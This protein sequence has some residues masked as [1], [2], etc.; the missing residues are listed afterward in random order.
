MGRRGAGA[1]V[2]LLLLGAAVALN[3][4]AAG[5][6]ESP[7]RTFK[8]GESVRGHAIR[9][10]EI[11]YPSAPR[12]ILVVGSLH[13]DERA[14]VG[15]VRELARSAPLEGVDLWL[16]PN[17]NPDGA[18]AHTRQNARGVDLNRNFPHRW[19]RSGN[20]F[21]Q[22]YSGRRP[23][24]EPESRIA[25]DL[26]ERL[27]PRITLWFHQPLGIVDLSGGDGRIERRFAR[28]AGLPVRRLPRYRGS[29]TSWQNTHQPEGTAFVAELPAGRLSDGAERH[30]ARAVRALIRQT[31]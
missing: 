24:S 31:G 22:Q 28:L 13:G 27:R 5:E 14:G 19:R 11:G 8:L 15:V 29:A 16:V 18:H 1:A 7:S 26:I 3:A 25:H 30:Y 6:P 10:T 21:D 9:A 4:S 17:L 2:A 23:L 20:P 12:K